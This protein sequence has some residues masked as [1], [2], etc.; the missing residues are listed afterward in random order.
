MITKIGKQLFLQKANANRTMKSTKHNTTANQEDNNWQ[1][2][3]PK[4]K[5]T[6]NVS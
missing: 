3:F 2:Y 4:N 6:I 5:A 1:L